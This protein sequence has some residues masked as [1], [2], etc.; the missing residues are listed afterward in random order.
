VSYENLFAAHVLPIAKFRRSA[1]GQYEPIRAVGTGF[2][3]G[4]GTFVSC[5]HCVSDPVENDEVYCAAIRTAGIGSQAYDKVSE[6]AYLGQDTNGSDLALARVD[7]SID[8]VLALA[9]EPAAWGEDVVASGYPL[10]V[11][12]RDPDTRQAKVDMNAMLLRGYVTR[13]RIDDR[14]GVLPVRAYELGM[15]ARPGASGSP[16]F[17]PHPLEVVGVVYG[18][19]D[20]QMGGGRPVTFAYAHHLSTLRE[21]RAAA[22]QGNP[23]HEFL[24]DQYR[25]LAE[26]QQD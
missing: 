3:F 8:P 17:R 5:W 12:T 19:Q 20:V 23:L 2:T 10:P 26:G 21:A 22:T 25:L 18:E 24:A 11:N 4:E 7:Y 14:P 13:L 1:P 15:M 6:L 9:E 16:L